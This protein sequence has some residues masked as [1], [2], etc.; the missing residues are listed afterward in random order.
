MDVV[1]L[2]SIV[3]I[4]AIAYIYVRKEKSNYAFAIIPLVF[5]PF[6]HLGAGWGYEVFSGWF[7]ISYPLFLLAVDTV[8]L[9]IACFFFGIAST[10]IETKRAKIVYC[11]MCG[12]FEALF[13][14]AL[15]K[16]LLIK[17]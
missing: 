3:I 9:V 12:G 2:S 5:V 15:L 1:C 6:A 14:F 13:T 16:D 11:I 8:A 17:R 4:L 7:N 10:A